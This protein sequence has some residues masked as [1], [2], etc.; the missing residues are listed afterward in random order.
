M[1]AQHQDL[2]LEAVAVRLDLGCALTSFDRAH[3]A[4]VLQAAARPPSVLAQRRT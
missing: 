4:A 1:D 2:W 3:A